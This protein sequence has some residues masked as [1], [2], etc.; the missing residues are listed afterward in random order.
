MQKR[1]SD[2]RL[3][4]K[5]LAFNQ[6]I[7]FIFLSYKN[8]LFQNS[9]ECKRASFFFSEKPKDKRKITLDGGKDF[10]LTFHHHIYFN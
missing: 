7:F 5:I 3:Q 2:F 9:I 4:R 10:N 1:I 8:I 6:N